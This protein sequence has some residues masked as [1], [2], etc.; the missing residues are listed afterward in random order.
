M[1]KVITLLV[2]IMFFVSCHK[3]STEKV[4]EDSMG[5]TE[6]IAPMTRQMAAAPAPAPLPPVDQIEKTDTDKQKIIKD[7]RL[8]IRVSEL[9]KAKERADSLVKKHG[10]YYASENFSNTDYESSYNLRVRIPSENLEKFL[11]EI[12]EGDDEIL[13]KEIDARDVTDQFIDL[14]TR[15]ENKKNYL[16][17]YSDLLKQ[18]KTVKEILDIEERIRVLEEE[19]ESTT[20]RLKYLSDQVD[21]STVELRLTKQKDFKFNP[22]K[23]D[24]FIER[25]KQSLSNGWHGLIDLVLFIIKIWPLWI[26]LALFIYLI[27]KINK[28]KKIK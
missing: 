10:G 5:Y 9:D 1:K 13:Y 11:T 12:E 26:I 14:E 23:R 24:N 3:S 6:G 25:L 17:R 19:I 21:Y 18:A 27:K 2:L 16:A 20:G 8:G 15:L 22:E 4:A 7:G 28:R